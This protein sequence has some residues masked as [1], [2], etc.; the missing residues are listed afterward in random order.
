[1]VP[2]EGAPGRGGSVA[3][4]RKMPP[5]GGLAHLDAELEQFA[6]DARR[7]SERIGAAHPTDQGLDFGA[8]LG[9]SG[10]A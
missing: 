8:R 3:A 5:D 2:Q 1:M 10:I 4:P 7:A 6:V 9:P